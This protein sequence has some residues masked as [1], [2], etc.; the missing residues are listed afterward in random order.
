M[1]LDPDWITI[2]PRPTRPRATSGGSPRPPKVDHAEPGAEAFA[3]LADPETAGRMLKAA[4]PARLERARADATRHPSRILAN[5][6]VNT[7][8]RNG[9]VEDIHAGAY[10]GYPSHG[11]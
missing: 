9:P 5:A 3:A 8:W 7:A 10:R 4:D 1:D 11:G 6:L 2:R